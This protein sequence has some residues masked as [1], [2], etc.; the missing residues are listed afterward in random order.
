MRAVLVASAAHVVDAIGA[1]GDDLAEP[2]E[3]PSTPRDGLSDIA[4]RVLDA[5]PVRVGVAPERL[6]RIA[7]C[8]VLDVLKVLPALE[9]AGLVQWTGQGWRLT[10][11]PK[12]A[13]QG[14]SHR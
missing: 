14:M 5:C 2:A 1:I 4:V 3:R 6:A 10:P 13:A 9:L 7:G 11:P 8:D 12:D